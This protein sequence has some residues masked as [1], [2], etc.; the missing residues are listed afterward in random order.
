MQFGRVYGFVTGRPGGERWLTVVLDTG[1]EIRTVRDEVIP[2]PL[3]SGDAHWLADQLVQETIGNEL[4]TDG[5]EAIGEGTMES[6]DATDVSA[7][8]CSPVWIVRRL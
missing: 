6:G 1:R 4:A 8:A 5:W 3:D 2:A 7:V